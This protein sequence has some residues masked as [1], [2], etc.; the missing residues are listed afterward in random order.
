MVIISV[1]N[2]DKGESFIM[3][4]T[5][6]K[7]VIREKC[8]K[9]IKYIDK[10][11]EISNGIYVKN[12]ESTHKEIAL[13]IAKFFNFNPRRTRKIFLSVAKEFWNYKWSWMNQP[14]S[15]SR[16]NDLSDKKFAGIEFLCDPETIAIRAIRN[17]PL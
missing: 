13:V 17:D 10:A 1:P 8:L 3:D 4:E 15:G 14:Y 16:T 12:D 9:V 6:I 7:D 5:K 11:G 2:V